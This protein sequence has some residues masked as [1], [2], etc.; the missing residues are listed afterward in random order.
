MGSFVPS[1]ETER[2]AML[3]AV[4]AGTFTDL[5]D[6]VPA[7]IRMSGKAQRK[8]EILLLMAWVLK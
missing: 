1:T 5:Y 4:G 8:L 2:Q 7:S 3:E 6:A